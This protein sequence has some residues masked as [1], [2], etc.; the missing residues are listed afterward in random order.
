MGRRLKQAAIVFVAVLAAAQLIRP[1]RA[2]PPTDPS[3]TIQASLGA[4]NALVP[5]LDRSC[6]SCHSNNTV[7]PPYANVAPLS[8]VMA[9]AV[10]KGRAVINFSEWSSYDSTTRHALLV[11]SCNAVSQQAMP[12][13]AWTTLNPE[14][15]LSAD[16]IAI[17]CAAARGGV[18]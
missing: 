16:E 9:D 14:T 7:W 15:R 10:K 6:G 5:I 3:H 12:G 13:T 4:T 2:N 11:A 1:E 8:W 17:I 18:R